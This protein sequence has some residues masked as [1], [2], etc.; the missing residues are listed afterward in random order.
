[1]NVYE[2]LG[3]LRLG[4]LAQIDMELQR[5]LIE[6]VKEQDEK[7]YP[8]TLGDVLMNEILKDIIKGAMIV[9]GFEV[10]QL[11][12]VVEEQDAREAKELKRDYLRSVI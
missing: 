11:H 6:F 9:K 7:P 4:I 1:M 5:N 10:E 2:K 3:G 8:H 12:K